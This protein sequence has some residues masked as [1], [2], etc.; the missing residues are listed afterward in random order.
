MPRFCGVAKL[1]IRLRT[2]PVNSKNILF[3]NNFVYFLFIACSKIKKSFRSKP[4]AVKFANTFF[5]LKNG[6]GRRSVRL[7]SLSSSNGTVPVNTNL[8]SVRYSKPFKI[9]TAFCYYF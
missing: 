3:L 6:G 2:E 1:G 8:T 9:T 7:L 5:A 4:L